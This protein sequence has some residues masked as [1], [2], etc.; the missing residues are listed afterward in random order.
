MLS[1]MWPGLLI[2]EDWLTKFVK[3]H[4]NMDAESFSLFSPNS[5]EMACVMASYPGKL[6]LLHQD[7]DHVE[8]DDDVSLIGAW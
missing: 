3:L 8:E 6:Q 4:E 5:H 2:L 1:E 7:P